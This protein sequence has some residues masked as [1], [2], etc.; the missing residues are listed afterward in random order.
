MDC[1]E[2]WG[3]LNHHNFTWVIFKKYPSKYIYILFKIV[4][5]VSAV[6]LGAIW[7]GFKTSIWCFILTHIFFWL[8]NGKNADPYIINPQVYQGPERV[9]MNQMV[10][11][12]YGLGLS[13]FYGIKV[14]WITADYLQRN[15]YVKTKSRIY[16]CIKKLTQNFP[17]LLIIR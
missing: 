9:M 11:Y 14:I 10:H 1:V 13:Y 15:M 16:M 8:N 6:I 12:F 5:F 7:I 2:Y 17:G 4:I 3:L